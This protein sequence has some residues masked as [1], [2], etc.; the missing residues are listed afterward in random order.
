MRLG[1]SYNLCSKLGSKLIFRRKYGNFSFARPFPDFDC[2][3]LI[4]ILLKVEPDKIYAP[5]T[6]NLNMGKRP[7]AFGI[8]QLYMCFR[9]Y[10][11]FAPR[12]ARRNKCTVKYLQRR[13]RVSALRCARRRPT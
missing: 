2:I 12:A 4:V 3:F 7:D 5:N 9:L 6:T 13:W 10:C 11:T 1:V 8:L